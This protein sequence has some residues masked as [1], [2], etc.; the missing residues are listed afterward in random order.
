MWVIEI[1][2]TVSF[3]VKLTRK[4]RNVEETFENIL[5]LDN[6]VQ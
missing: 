4:L 5:I 2:G 1:R 3:I 6:G